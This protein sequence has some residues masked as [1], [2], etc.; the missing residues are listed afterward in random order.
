MDK[1]PTSTAAPYISSVSAFAPAR[2]RALAVP[3]A[4]L[5]ALLSSLLMVAS[6]ASADS[7]GHI[8]GRVYGVDGDPTVGAV[9]DV[10]SQTADGWR[11][12]YP[13]GSTTT[14]GTGG[15]FATPALPSGTYRIAAYD[16][17]AGE[18]IF[19]DGATTV[20]GASDIPVDQT[21]NADVGDVQMLAT[22]LVTGRITSTSGSPLAGVAVT[23]YRL[24]DGVWS[25]GSAC[26]QRDGYGTVRTDA[27]GRYRLFGMAP[28]TWRLEFCPGSNGAFE[29]WDDA[30]TLASATTFTLAA[31]EAKRGLDAQVGPAGSIAGTVVATDASHPC[32]S[33]YADQLVDGSWTRTPSRSTTAS[34]GSYTLVGLRPGTYRVEAVDDGSCGV[35][36][37]T[38]WA[39]VF[40]GN[41]PD[42]VRASDVVVTAAATTR[43]GSMT[44]RP[45]G[46][47]LEGR[48]LD[49]FGG[50]VIGWTPTLF[51]LVGSG[52]GTWT[53]IRSYPLTDVSGFLMDD[54][55]SGTFRVGFVSPDRSTTKFWGG[56]T[57]DTARNL[58]VRIG[59]VRRSFDIRFGERAVYNAVKPTVVGTPWVGNVLRAN[60]GVHRP[61]YASIHYQWLLDGFLIDGQNSSGLRLLPSYVGHTVTALVTGTIQGYS[62]SHTYSTNTPTV[63]KRPVNLRLTGANTRSGTDVLTVNAGTRLAAGAAT[64]VYRRSGTRWVLV[65]AT[66]IQSLGY[67]RFALADGAKRRAAS[68]YAKVGSTAS[69]SADRSNTL[70]LR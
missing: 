32:V 59:Q 24:V 39:S 40:S 43:A 1:R 38:D 29:F 49:E 68:Y 27:D 44:L 21:Q 19:W 14:S 8:T 11:T 60:P 5:L 61:D 65:K 48:V 6:P 3:V 23:P 18:A 34:D 52:G 54:A 62:S 55:P 70:A 17:A 33:V 42:A 36:N 7:V 41:Q 66:R 37:T 56:D 35:N 4:V 57:V 13:G 45:G 2:R 46:G 64:Y 25:G 30:A 15:A 63:I 53:A 28:G 47:A 50:A 9:I 16:D 10:Y 69:T 67:V 22:S 51:A 12:I 20:D 31:D 58:V 26:L